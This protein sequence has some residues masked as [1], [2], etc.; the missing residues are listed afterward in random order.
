MNSASFNLS[1]FSS[2]TNVPLISLL[3]L[4]VTCCSN[5]CSLEKAESAN[6][7]SCCDFPISH[8][9]NLLSPRL[10]LTSRSKR[11]NWMGWRSSCKSGTLEAKSVSE[12]SPRPIFEAHMVSSSST[13]LQ[14]SSRSNSSKNGWKRSIRALKEVRCRNCL[15]ETKSTS[16]KE[17]SSVLQ[18]VTL[19]L[20][21][22]RLDS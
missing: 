2:F 15:S 6:R 8:L 19:S 13:M 3:V 14:T 4:I 11:L 12:Q 20:I 17:E 22:S 9:Q 1:D 7:L 5:F 21:H 10:G 16:W 18:K